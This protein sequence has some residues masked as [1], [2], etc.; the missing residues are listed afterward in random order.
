[1]RHSR[2]SLFVKSNPDKIVDYLSNIENVLP[3]LPYTTGRSRGKVRLEFR[4][5]R[6][7]RFVDEFVVRSIRQDRS[8]ILLFEGSRSRIR[9][10]F[11]PEE[12]SVT[13]LIDYDGPRGW[14]VGKYLSEIA[15]VLVYEA[16]RAVYSAGRREAEAFA[17]LSANLARI[18]WVSKLLM[19]SV[20]IKNETRVVSKGGLLDYI[21]SLIMEEKV[22]SKYPGLYISGDGV[23]SKMRLLFLNGELKGVYVVL[24]DKEFFGDENVLKEIGGLMRIRVYGI[25]RPEL[26]L[27]S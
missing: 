6:V 2:V 9:F 12:S 3:I 19:K 16:D 20:M 21:E 8:L 15:S 14:I 22:F 17:D 7:F 1:M 24:G 27:R 25:I 10:F 13:V 11:R 5:L 26:V 23:N 4:R 18:S